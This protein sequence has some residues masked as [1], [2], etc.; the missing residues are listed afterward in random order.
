MRDERN[1]SIAASAVAPRLA[2]VGG[3]TAGHVQPALAV[4][5]AYRALNPESHITFLGTTLGFEGDLIPAAGYAVELIPGWPVFGSGLSGKVRAVTNTVAGMQAARRIF[6]REQVEVLLSFGSY[7]SGG[8]VLAARRLRIPIAIHEPNVAPG[9]SNRLLARMADEIFIGWPAAAAAFGN[10]T[11]RVTGVPI[12]AA[13][14]GGGRQRVLPDGRR[15]RL[16]ILG[17]S[18]GAAFLNRRVAAIARELTNRGWEL[19]VHHQCGAGSDDLVRRIYVEHGVDANVSTFVG[20]IAALYDWADV[21]IT[22]AGAITLA[23]IAAVGLPALLVPLAVASENHQAANARAFSEASGCPW[24]TEADWHVS[25]V[26]DHVESLMGNPQRYARV[27]SQLDAMADR[28]AA[29][30]IARRCAALA[31]KGHAFTEARGS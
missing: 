11:V 31:S 19:D 27:S 6:E 22:S 5:E 9:L 21:A 26:A 30:T 3:G 13:L 8:P 18:L 12:R 4:A 28:Q 14:S 10:R 2:I 7:A 17:G 29:S 23:E 15:R 1:T 20:D 25:L 24:I 16:L